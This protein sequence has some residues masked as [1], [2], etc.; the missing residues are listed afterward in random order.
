MPRR[1]SEREF[2]ALVEANQT[3][4]GSGRRLGDRMISAVRM[5]LVAGATAQQ[6]AD[7]CEVSR[8]AVGAAYKRLTGRR[9]ID[10]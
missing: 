7:W 4:P 5:V 9:M 10:A 8:Q 2:D 3:R 1:L 6:A